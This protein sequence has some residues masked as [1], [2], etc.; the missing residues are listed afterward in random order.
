MRPLVN[1]AITPAVAAAA[2][3]ARQTGVTRCVGR[4]PVDSRFRYRYPA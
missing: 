4:R 3:V 2:N 1:G